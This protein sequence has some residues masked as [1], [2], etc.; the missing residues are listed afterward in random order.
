[1]KHPEKIYHIAENVHWAKGLEQGEYRCPSLE[2]EGF[3]HF[4]TVDQVIATAN[5]HYHGVSGLLL[6]TIF[7]DKLTAR[8]KYEN[9]PTGEY[10]PHLYGPL[11]LDAVEKVRAFEPDANGD[12][13]AMPD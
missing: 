12:F 9:V 11:N 3:I 4:S 6:V 5:R 8:L 1:M 13:L 2:S 10:F 7:A